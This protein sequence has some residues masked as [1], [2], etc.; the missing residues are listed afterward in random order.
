VE[1]AHKQIPLKLISVVKL[2]YKY[3]EFLLKLPQ[4]FCFFDMKNTVFDCNAVER[5][6][7][8]LFHE[9]NLDLEN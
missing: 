7:Y 3:L 5:Q 1:G 6:E 4:S 8:D 2:T 9:F